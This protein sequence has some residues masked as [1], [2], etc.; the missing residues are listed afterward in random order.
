[1]L[2]WT[3]IVKIKDWNRIDRRHVDIAE[4]QDQPFCPK[5]FRS[6]TVKGQTNVLLTEIL[7][8]TVWAWKC[9][10]WII[11]KILKSA[12]FVEFMQIVECVI[13]LSFLWRKIPSSICMIPCFSVFN[14]FVG[15]VSSVGRAWCWYRQGCE[16]NPYRDH[17]SCF[18]F[19]LFLY[20]SSAICKSNRF[21]HNGS[22]CACWRS[23]K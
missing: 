12:I 19:F 16:F 5:N 13:L 17:N 22:A 10:K 9:F 1:M 3:P 21:A 11:E 18:S 14:Y 23:I 6:A 7:V 2:R 20:I 15:S 8:K 4:L